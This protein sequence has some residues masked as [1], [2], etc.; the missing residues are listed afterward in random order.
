M[1]WVLS[2]DFTHVIP[3]VTLSIDIVLQAG[4][5]W[6]A[7]PCLLM[8]LLL[9]PLQ[10]VPAYYLTMEGV[11][12]L[13]IQQAKEINQAQLIILII[14]GGVMPLVSHALGLVVNSLF[15]RTWCWLTVS[16]SCAVTCRRASST[17][18]SCE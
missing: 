9:P 15:V 2:A 5:A 17:C 14:E 7:M 11:L 4:V 16:L 3:V 10:V 6:R 18:G 8:S 1:W 13:V 12:Q